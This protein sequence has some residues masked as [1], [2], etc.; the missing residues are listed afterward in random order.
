M[1]HINE[2]KINHRKR[3]YNNITELIGSRENPTPVIMINER[4]N[5]N[6]GFELGLKLERYNSFGSIKDRVALK[7]LKN[8]PV[9][10]NQ[11]ILEASSGNTALALAAMGNALN[12][13]VEVAIPERAPEEKK[14]LLK[15]LGV[16]ELWEAEDELCPLFPNE[17]AR[18]LA[19]GLAESVAYKGKYVYLNQYENALNVQA[20]YESTGPEIWHQ[21][22]GKIDYFFA[23]FGTGATI[24]GVAAFLKEQNPDIRVIGIEPAHKEH[25]LSGMKRISDLAEEYV[26]NILDMSLIDEVVEVE[27]EA[28]YFMGIKLAREAG[29]LVGPSTG[30]IVDAARKFGA[31]HAGVGVAISPDDAFKYVHLYADYLERYKQRQLAAEMVS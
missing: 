17:G 16:S 23:G 8:T 7:M 28:A 11:T 1:N 26:P 24:T 20:H 13:P 19:K 18:G 27:D 5:T 29:L 14:L 4:I 25:T 22:D 9:L 2:S 31:A 3:V 6:P 21:F 30:A 15:I 10:K 12:M